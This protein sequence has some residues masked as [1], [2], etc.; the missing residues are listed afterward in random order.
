MDKLSSQK[1]N[2]YSAP[3]NPQPLSPILHFCFVYKLF[4]LLKIWRIPYHAQHK[5]DK[6]NHITRPNRRAYCSKHDQQL[7][8]GS[9]LP[10]TPTR[11]VFFPFINSIH[12]STASCPTVNTEQTPQQGLFSSLSPETSVSS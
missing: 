9:K 7:F 5:T 11:P 3:P 8:C 2:K 12:Q 1:N 4:F 10:S 6:H